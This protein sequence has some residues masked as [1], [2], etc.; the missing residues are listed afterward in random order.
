VPLVLQGRL[1]MLV[2]KLMRGGSLRA[3]LQHPEMRQRICWV[4]R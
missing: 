4:A 3:A 2:M 1:L